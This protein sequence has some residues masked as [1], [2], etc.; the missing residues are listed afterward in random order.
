MVLV[1]LFFIINLFI[2]STFSVNRPSSQSSQICAALL[3]GSLLLWPLFASG[4]APKL[5]KDSG[6]AGKEAMRFSVANVCDLAGKNCQN[7]IAAN[8]WIEPGAVNRFNEQTNAL[9]EHTTVVIDS[10]GGDLQAGMELGRAIRG[11]RFNTRIGVLKPSTNKNNVNFE[12]NSGRCLSA[13]V[14]SFLG[15]IERDL[16]STDIVGFHGLTIANAK[17]QVGKP[18]GE[19]RAKEVLGALGR[20]IELMGA[21]RRI[22]D[23]MLLAKGDNIQRIPTETAKQLNLDNQQPAPKSPWRLQVTDSGS[24]L[25]IVNEKQ[26]KG[27]ATIT[28][29]LTKPANGE[30]PAENLRLIV[31][32]K[33]YQ[34]SFNPNDMKL[35][36]PESATVLMRARTKVLGTKTLVG[37]RQN[38]EGMQMV[39]NIPNATQETLIQS[40]NFELEIAFPESANKLGLERITPFGTAGLKG[41]IVILKK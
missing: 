32:V 21:D 5:E 19:E 38:G 37:W 12:L 34:R 1:L 2:S 26:A 9:P 6:P 23:F 39:M 16:D 13:C 22:T 25:A 3:L 28:L 14:L 40:L 15:G 10:A 17:D 36:F 29:A 4:A 18:A 35:A 27:Q 33:P 31:F 41:A 8:G 7:M 30:N 11:K 24:V 20:Y